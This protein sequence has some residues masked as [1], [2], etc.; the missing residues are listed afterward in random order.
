MNYKDRYQEW[1]NYPNLDE[2]LRI[3]LESMKGDE[4]LIED[5]FYQDLSFGTAGLRGKMGV[6]SNRMN[7]HVIARAT[8]ALADEIIANNG[9]AQGVAIAYDCRNNSEAFAHIAARI[10]ASKG[11]KTYLFTS[12]RPTPELSFAVRYYNCIAGINITASHNPREYNGYKVYWTPGSQVKSEIADSILAKINQL[13]TFV[14]INNLKSLTELAE[15]GNLIF[16]DKEVDEAFYSEV[17]KTS[18]R[19]DVDKDIKIVYTPLFGTGNIPVRHVLD[20]QG[21]KNVHVVKDQELPN[22]NFDGVPYPNPEELQ[23]FEKAREL[24]YELNADL[25]IATDPDADRLGAQVM[26]RGEIKA[27]NG[28]QVGVILIKYILEAMA[29]KGLITDNMAIVKS[30]VTGE[31]GAKVAKKY[32]VEMVDVLTGFKNICAMSN[33]WEITKE[34][35][36]IIG[37]EESIG[38][39]VGTF[40]RDKDA[41]TSAILMAEACAYYKAQEKTLYDVLEDLFKEFGYH[42]EKGTSIVLEGIE[43]AKRIKRM[44]VEFREKFPKTVLDTKAIKKIDYLQEKEYN[45]ETGEVTKCPIEVT[46]ALSVRYNDGTWYTLRPSGTEPKIKLYLYVQAETDEKALAKLDAFNKAVLDII[47]SIE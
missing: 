11:I 27:L 31:L 29:E 16:I 22:G 3:E 21:Y 44:M 26:H 1:L 45:L 25:I 28:N 32:G 9:Q 15:D 33:E 6:G 19:S 40:V 42:H 17:L 47:Y 34:K 36:Y 5:C 38:Y 41:V 13:P 43:G 30:I 23:V 14:D 46:D 8:T 18:L 4:K 12:L 7:V 2:K 35:T 24:A 10:M 39:N 37:Y 20:V